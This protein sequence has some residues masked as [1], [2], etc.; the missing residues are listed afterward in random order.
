[1]SAINGASG[2]DITKVEYQ[3]GT[4]TITLLKDKYGD[5]F[6]RVDANNNDLMVFSN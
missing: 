5:F 2:R 4:Q 1:M 6:K 3:V